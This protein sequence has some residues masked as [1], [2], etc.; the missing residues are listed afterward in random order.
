M[1]TPLQSKSY[2]LLIRAA[3]TD[4]DVAGDWRIE[5][6]VRRL[7]SSASD[8][9]MYVEKASGSSSRSLFRSA[10][11]EVHNSVRQVKLWL[12]VLD[13]LGRITPEAASPLHDT[14][15]DVHRLVVTAL[16][17]SSVDAPQV[18]A[19][20]SRAPNGISSSA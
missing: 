16:R 11:H 10:L 13:D 14:A 18:N 8:L 7:F 6:V 9:G 17:T 4:I 20:R 12:R 5:A 15:E 1:P 19:V 3:S 2:E